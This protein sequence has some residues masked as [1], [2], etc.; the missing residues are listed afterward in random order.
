MKK[1]E[2]KM[3]REKEKSRVEKQRLSITVFSMRLY[4]LSPCSDACVVWYSVITEIVANTGCRNTYT[5]TVR[6][7]HRYTK[8]AHSILYTVYGT[9]PDTHTDP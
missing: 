6:T 1:I 3:R 5:S 2:N 4:K 9:C 8:L 7:E